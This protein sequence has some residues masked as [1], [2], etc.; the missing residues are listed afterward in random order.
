MKVIGKPSQDMEIQA[1]RAPADQEF[2]SLSH[3]SI[4][5][6]V[7]ESN[8][9]DCGPFLGDPVNLP[10]ERVS[11]WPRIT[12]AHRYKGSFILEAKNGSNLFCLRFN[13]ED[14]RN[15]YYAIKHLVR[16]MIEEGETD[17]VI[18]VD[19]E[20]A[21]HPPCSLLVTFVHRFVVTTFNRRS[22][23]RKGW[24]IGL[25]HYVEITDTD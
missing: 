15:G 5:T 12:S 23:A 24:L 19:D 11:D 21:R 16:G 17:K 22:G 13:P 10:K 4:E 14:Q 18:S 7:N 9:P 20:L 6:L 2:G 8:E 1:M 3:R 25:N